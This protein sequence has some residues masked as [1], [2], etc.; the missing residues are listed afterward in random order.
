MQ[1][2]QKQQIEDLKALYSKACHDIFAHKVCNSHNLP[3][4]FPTNQGMNTLASRFLMF[5]GE[6]G[7]LSYWSLCVLG[8][9]YELKET[10]R[11]YEERIMNDGTVLL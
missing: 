4:V 7:L 9:D 11:R 3:R 5:V 10:I 8:Q 1:T 2:Q 6:C